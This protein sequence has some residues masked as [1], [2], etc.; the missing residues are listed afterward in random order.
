MMK[1]KE[2]IKKIDVD[3]KMSDL[4]TAEEKRAIRDDGAKNE[5]DKKLKALEE[6]RKKLEQAAQE[7][8]Q[9]K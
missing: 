2:N 9:L 4:A 5:R 8:E 6:R 1:S 7:G 3:K